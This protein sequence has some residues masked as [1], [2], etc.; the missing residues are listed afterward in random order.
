VKNLQKNYAPE[1]CPQKR[2][3]VTINAPKA[4]LNG[5][6]SR[7]VFSGELDVLIELVRSVDARCVAEFGCNNGRTALAV[8]RNVPSVERYIGVDVPAGYSFA[9]KV[10]AKEVPTIPGELALDDPQFELKL[11]PRGTFDLTAG[12]LPSCDLVFVD[13]D[14]SE[15]AVRHDRDLALRVVRSGGLI[16]YH[17]DNGLRTVDVSRV[18]DDLADG[19]ADIQHVAGTWFA[20]ERVK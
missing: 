18:L 1:Y 14:H 17:D 11:R 20:V 10:Q 4:D 19:G 7:Y 13:G 2:A 8:L 16:V 5:L 6:P 12:D 15:A 3:T 9:C